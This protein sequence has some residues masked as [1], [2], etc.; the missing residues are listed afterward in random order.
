MTLWTPI[1]FGFQNRY[2]H[3]ETARMNFSV[4]FPALECICKCTILNSMFHLLQLN[5]HIVIVGS[6]PT[7][8]LVPLKLMKLSVDYSTWSKLFLPWC[9]AEYKSLFTMCAFHCTLSNVRSSCRTLNCFEKQWHI[10]SLGIYIFP[11][12]EEKQ[13]KPSCKL[14]G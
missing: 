12:K 4:L 13:Q 14:Q 6:N 5:S 9:N 11:S 3:Y 8:F 7:P 10:L 2:S 1:N